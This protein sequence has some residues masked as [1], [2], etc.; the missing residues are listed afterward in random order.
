MNPITIEDYLKLDYPVTFV[1]KDGGYQA[2]Y[3]DLG[4]GSI[5]AWAKTLKKA[6]EDIEES[7]KITIKYWHEKGIPIPLPSD[8]DSS[9]Y[10]GRFVLRIPKVLHAGLV[11][12]A[13]KNGISLNSYVSFLLSERNIKSYR[14]KVPNL[15]F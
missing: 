2:W 8:T 9:Q 14:T 1:K 10:S 12:E 3:P 5:V 15:L 13:K 11:E 6:F 7:R 4:S